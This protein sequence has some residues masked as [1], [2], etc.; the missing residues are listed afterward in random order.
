MLPKTVVLETAKR[1]TPEPNDFMSISALERERR[2]LGPLPRDFHM[3]AVP[4]LARP[5][6]F[7]P[8]WEVT[9]GETT[10]RY[11]CASIT[12]SDGPSL[13]A[14]TSR[15]WNGRLAGQLYDE[16]VRPALEAD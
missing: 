1:I 14:I 4:G 3:R 5:V 10:L 15:R 12:V 7:F 11:A 8:S 16:V 13:H 2:R 9:I 6:S